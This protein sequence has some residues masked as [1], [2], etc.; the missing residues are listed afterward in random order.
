MSRKKQ[1][2]PV[3]HQNTA[4]VRTSREITCLFRESYCDC[5]NPDCLARFKTETAVTRIFSTRETM[6]NPEK[7][8]QLELC[9]R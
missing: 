8:S 4:I 2:C 7:A 1:T 5:L 9:L 3:C 6:E